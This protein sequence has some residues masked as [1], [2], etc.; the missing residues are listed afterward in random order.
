[1]NSMKTFMTIFFTLSIA[2][3]VFA[4]EIICSLNQGDT[5]YKLTMQGDGAGGEEIISIMVTAASISATRLGHQ[6]QRP[7]GTQDFLI[8]D[9]EESEKSENSVDEYVLNKP[10][11]G[12]S[13]SR[14]GFDFTQVTFF[15]QGDEDIALKVEGPA[16]SSPLIFTNCLTG[17]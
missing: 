5:R 1:M 16:L 6:S 2:G 11:K 4:A 10:I 9:S 17:N 14:D 7:V 15:E 8:D 12:S 13:F 3:S